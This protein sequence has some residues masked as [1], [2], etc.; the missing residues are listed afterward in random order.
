MKKSIYTMISAMILVSAMV[1]TLL[2]G[3]CFADETDAADA[4]TVKTEAV[5]TEAAETEA[6]D[7][8]T[9]ETETEKS[10][11]PAYDYMVLVN[12]THK[13]PEDWESVVDLVEAENKYGDTYLVEAKALESFLALRD[14]LLEEGI[15]IELDSVYRSVAEQQ[16]LWDDWTVEYGED[17]VKATVAPPGFSEHHTGLAIDVCLDVDGVRIDE[18]EDMLKEEEIFAK[19]HE[20]LAEFGFILRFPKDKKDITGYDYEPWHFRYIDD[21]EIA[22]EIMDKGLTYEEYL[23]AVPATEVVI[24]YGTSQ[25][26]TNEDMDEAIALIREEFDTWDGCEL[27]SIR[28]VSD[29]SLTEDDLDWLNNLEEDK[30]YTQ[31]IEF[32]SDFHSPEEQYGAWEPDMEYQDWQWWLARSEDGNWELITWGY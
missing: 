20:R 21:P 12:K 2:A 24:D 25:L 26:Y 10:E 15:D 29:D 23:G 5:E 18:N 19:V 30:N 31:C 4:E 13:L 32:V 6:M 17:Y 16:K 14:A 3:F 9:A 27:H 7:A 22:K 11:V 1:V 28:Y 8:D